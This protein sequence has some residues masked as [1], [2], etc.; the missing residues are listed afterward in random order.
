MNK[1]FNKSI[2]PIVLLAASQSAYSLDYY[3]QQSLY[4]QQQMLREVQQQRYYNELNRQQYQ[5]QQYQNSV[6]PIQPIQLN[7]PADTFYKW[8]VIRGMQN[9]R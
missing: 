1:L 8:Q 3:E 9:G 5:Q 7:D 4:N 2:L 6:Q